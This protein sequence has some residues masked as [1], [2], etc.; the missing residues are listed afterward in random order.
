MLVI[1][2]EPEKVLKKDQKPRKKR[3]TSRKNQDIL[4]GAI[5]VFTE[6]GFESSSMDKIAEVAGVSKRTVYN[7]FPSK[8]A[9][10]QTIVFDFFQQG[11]DIQPSEYL[12]S[13]PI[14]DQLKGFAKGELYAVDDPT[15]LKLTRLL[16][17]VF[18][19]KTDL[20]KISYEQYRKNTKRFIKWLKA[21]KTDKKLKF[22]NPKL[23]CELFFGMIDGC[24]DLRALYTNGESLK[25]LEPILDE[26]I[27]I[28]LSRYG[29]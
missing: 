7:H 2:N 5:K 20:M 18:L 21:A 29:I 14:K 22:K 25:N 23:V 4:E 28:F 6:Y 11:T 1:K 24:L 9:L 26:V 3:D 16:L 8:E 15:R 19:I 17:S 27:E 10:F 12:K 13:V